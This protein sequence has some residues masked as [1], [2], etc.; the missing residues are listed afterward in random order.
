MNNKIQ[1]FNNPEFGEIR[2]VEID[3]EAWFAGKDV[4]TVLGYIKPTQAIHS[5]V[6]KED[7]CAKGLLDSRGIMQN[8][9]VINESGLFSLIL[10]SKLASAKKFKRWVTSEV[11]PALHKTGGY[12]LPVQNNP[13]DVL[14]LHY[15]AI[16]EVDKKI[17]IVDERVEEV[18]E[19]LQQFK[20]DMPIM[21]SEETRITCAIGNRL[22]VLLGG[23]N[24]KA[25]K[26]KGLKRSMRQYLYG[27]LHRAFGI[28]TYRELKRRHC[29]K[30]IELIQTYEPPMDVQDRIY[31]TNNSY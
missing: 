8:T 3:G 19:E 29:E 25:Y 22:I 17:D 30:A 2:T 11:L 27:E 20:M 31:I 9:I 14:E 13:L 15:Q 23:R 24:S 10:G 26:D 16:K 28:N 18:R 5:N 4:A 21:P 1:I 12:Q 6:D 7:S